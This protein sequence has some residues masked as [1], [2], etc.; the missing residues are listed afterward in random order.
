MV[1]SVSTCWKHVPGDIS[2]SDDT[3]CYRGVYLVQVNCL[4][5]LTGCLRSI[6]GATTTSGFLKLRII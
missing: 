1:S 5:E 6:L 3:A 2:L 4:D